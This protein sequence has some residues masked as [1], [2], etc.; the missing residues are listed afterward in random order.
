MHRILDHLSLAA[1][2][3]GA[4]L[5]RHGCLV[6]NGPLPWAPPILSP[7]E[8]GELLLSALISIGAGTQSNLIELDFSAIC[9]ASA[10]AAASNAVA[11]V[12]L[13][14][15]ST[16]MRDKYQSPGVLESKGSLPITGENAMSFCR[17]ATYVPSVAQDRE[18]APALR[19][20]E[21]EPR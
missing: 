3:L 4:L 9:G 10:A 20:P 18:V 5:L 11:G 8:R 2:R 16:S 13:P 1:L 7:L 17:A 19:E 6:S 14:L 15:A 21:C 12:L